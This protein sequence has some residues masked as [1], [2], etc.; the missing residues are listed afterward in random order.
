[1]G[2]LPSSAFLQNDLYEKINIKNMDQSD[3]LDLIFLAVVQLL[4]PWLIH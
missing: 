2:D 1:M 3:N 4:A